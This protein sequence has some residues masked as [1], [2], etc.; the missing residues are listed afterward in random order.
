MFR[1]SQHSQL[2]YREQRDLDSQEASISQDQK[3]R[4]LEA[5]VNGL[6]G[7]VC[8]LLEK[9]EHLRV[10]LRVSEGLP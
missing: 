5:E 2:P 6:Q 8:Y 3:V 7:L 1:S 9:N 10:R 4:E